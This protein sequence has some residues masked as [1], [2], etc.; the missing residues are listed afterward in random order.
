MVNYL[1]NNNGFYVL[2]N[3]ANLKWFSDRVNG[4]DKNSNTIID[5]YNNQI[6]GIITDGLNNLTLGPSWIPIGY[7]QSRPFNGILDGMNGI[8]SGITIQGKSLMTNGLIRL[9]RTI[10]RCL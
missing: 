8:I 2:K 7:S 1:T 4:Y 5:D 9:F 3:V 6:V 10:R